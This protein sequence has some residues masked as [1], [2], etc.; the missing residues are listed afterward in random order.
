MTDTSGSQ[1]YSPADLLAL[2]AQVEDLRMALE[3]IRSGG[4]DAVMLGEPGAEQL[5][6]L[7]SADQTY[8]VIVEQM[9]EAAATISERGTVLYANRRLA[10]LVG[11]ER[12]D[13][14]GRAVGT[15]LSSPTAGLLAAGPGQSNRA[16]TELIKSG[17]A[18]LPVLVS[19]TGMDLEGTTV[20]CLIAADLSSQR[21]A[22]QRLA[23]SEERYRLLAENASDVVWQRDAD[24]AIV[25]V[26]PSVEAVLGWTPAQLLGTHPQDIVRPADLALTATNMA[27][28]ASGEDIRPFEI[29]FLTADGSYRWMSLHSHP[30]TAADGSVTGVI[31]GLRDV[32]EQVLARQEFERLWDMSVDMLAVVGVDGY[33][34]AV[35]ASWERVLGY[36]PDE[37]TSKPYLDFVHPEDVAATQQEARALLEAAHVTV[38]FQNRYR[39]KDGHYRWLEWNARTGDEGQHIYCVVRDVT[40]SKAAAD[41]LRTSEWG[42]TQA[43]RM[44]HVGSWYLDVAT[45]HVQWSDELYLMQGLDPQL[46]PP[47]YTE[48]SKL[49]T[50]ESWERLSTALPRT[51]ETGVPYEL[52]LEMVRPDGTHGWMLARGEVLRDFDNVVV[53]LQGVAMDITERKDAADALAAAQQQYRLIAENATDAV[54]LI[55]VQGLFTWASPATERV[56]GYGQK[57][58][59]GT[60]SFD[61]VQFEDRPILQSAWER[62]RRGEMGVEIEERARVATGEY[63]WMSRLSSPVLDAEGAIA[64]FIATLRDIHDQVLVRQALARSEETLRLAM[65]GSAQGMAVVGLH[66]RFLRVN[67]A[68]CQMVGRDSHWLAEHTE[69]DLMHPDDVERDEAVRD[70]LLAGD[71]DHDV[72]EGRLVTA[73]GQELWI[74]HSLSLVRDEHAMPLF[75]VSQYQDIT[76]ARATRTDLQYRAEHDMLTGLI[77]RE[78]LQTRMATLLDY[79][80][81]RAGVPAVLFCDLDHFKDINDGHGHAAG[82]HVLREVAKRIASVL[83]ETDEVARL[84]GDEFVVVLPGVFGDAAARDVAEQ[85]RAAVAQ[86][87]P[88]GDKRLIITL[89]VGVALARPGIEAHRLLR[90]ADFALYQAKNGGRNQVRTFEPL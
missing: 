37:I 12:G 11:C 89:S 26:S 51:R 21:A 28:L 29:Q 77:N 57:D 66:G 27:K 16:E 81:R 50:P 25:W 70:R 60:P 64:G 86:P 8:R 31:A 1:Q 75:Y 65:E 23:E 19:V 4:V 43:Q 42:L 15:L 78:H 47:D 44:A 69:D 63:R 83:R 9:G 32:H 45:N 59:V 35:N 88:V 71:G 84:G 61:L 36:T 55:D 14:L 5:Y 24:Q 54:L 68:L 30:T 7:T 90:D 72:R 73:G 76:E 82:D 22:G 58:L 18:R 53:G 48:H 87:L 56:L 46:P 33:V 62:N 85:I 34:T 39:G 20:R 79:E 10:E 2:Q 40:A 6:S 3:A 80:P 17:G 38:S 41:A 67:A 52:E 74:Q 13:L 49:F